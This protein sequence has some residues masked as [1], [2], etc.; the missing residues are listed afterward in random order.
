MNFH[1]KIQLNPINSHLY[2]PIKYIKSRIFMGIPLFFHSE[3]HEASFLLQ[4]HGGHMLRSAVAHVDETHG[5]VAALSIRPRDA[6]QEP[7]PGATRH[8]E[9]GEIHKAIGHTNITYLH[10]H[11][12]ITQHY[13]TLHY[14]NINITLHTHTHPSI[15]LSNVNMYIY[16]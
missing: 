10:V 5:V 8:P 15:Y 16:I 1:H 3:T 4:L 2:N 9:R 6:L 7:V 13:I 11:T 14:I 12:S